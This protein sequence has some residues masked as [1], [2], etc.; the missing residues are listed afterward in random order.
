M[1]ATRSKLEWKGDAAPTHGATKPLLFE[2]PPLPTPPP[3]KKAVSGLQSSSKRQPRQLSRSARYEAE[4]NRRQE[5][6]RAHGTTVAKCPTTYFSPTGFGCWYTESI[7]S[8]PATLAVRE[9]WKRWKPE[10]TLMNQ[11]SDFIVHHCNCAL[12][13][14]RVGWNSALSKL[15][16]GWSK[17][18][19]GKAKLARGFS[20]SR[21]QPPVLPAG[22]A[23]LQPGDIERSVYPTIDWTTHWNWACTTVACSDYYAR[24]G[25]RWTV[26]ITI[27][28]KDLPKNI[29]NGDISWGDT[30]QRPEHDEAAL[31]RIGVDEEAWMRV[32]VFYPPAESERTWIAEV[33]VLH[34]DEIRIA[35]SDFTSLFS[36][37]TVR[38]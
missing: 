20:V 4:F 5:W 21:G 17:D 32:F 7:R 35:E 15:Y 33:I 2:V 38:W 22:I 13:R 26:Y 23:S 29:R 6:L 30:Y 37:D 9:M 1:A 24:F 11:S 28:S 8:E 25:H 27:Y 14:V 16:H 3:P 19:S 36:P 12:C 10:T 18:E 34:D 31:H